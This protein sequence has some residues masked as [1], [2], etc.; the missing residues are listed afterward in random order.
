M[1]K[2]VT[3]EEGGETEVGEAEGNGEGELDH[4]GTRGGGVGEDEV[5]GDGDKNVQEEEGPGDNCVLSVK[6]VDTY[7]S[8]AGPEAPELVA[9]TGEAMC[10]RHPARQ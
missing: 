10:V 2:T 7:P 6:L 3:S 8:E 5:E 1:V 4:L 9:S